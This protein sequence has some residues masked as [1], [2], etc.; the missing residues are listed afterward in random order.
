MMIFEFESILLMN[1]IPKKGQGDSGSPLT[2][3]NQVIGVVSWNIPCAR[4]R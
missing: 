3:N 1:L 2:A 4:G